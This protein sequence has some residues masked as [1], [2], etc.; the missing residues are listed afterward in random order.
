MS[1]GMKHTQQ[2]A[3]SRFGLAASLTVV[4]LGSSCVSPQDYET[5]VAQVKVYQT[6]VHD[7]EN[8]N[9]DQRNRIQELEALL[10]NGQ[11]GTLNAGFDSDLVARVNEYEALL[12]SLGDSP[13][14]GVQRFDLEDGVLFMVPDAVLFDLGSTKISA[15]GRSALL[16][17]ASQI[18]AQK[19]G[20]IWVRG[21]TDNTPIVKP[22]TRQR[23]PN[24]NLQ[25]SAER[26]LEVA[27]LLTTEGRVKEGQVAVMG[28]GPH[29]P[30]QANDTT[31]HKRLNRRV[32]I[33]VMNEGA[34][35]L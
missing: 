35:S 24:G 21:H 10:A 8:A 6:R 25:L 5:S 34:S 12:N 16:D 20:R 1:T 2:R 18:R 28:F 17:V 9:N 31:E 29:E 26:A 13:M 19:H 30:I 15:E 23:F 32:E 14:E 3:I 7:L 22:A 33:F 4:A 11:M 27:T